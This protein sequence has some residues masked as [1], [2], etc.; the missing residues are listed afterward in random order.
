MGAP[1]GHWT[2]SSVVP[3]KCQQI[4][5]IQ[6]ENWREEWKEF[7]FGRFQ[8]QNDFYSGVWN[9]IEL[10]LSDDDLTAVLICIGAATNVESV[11]LSACH[12]LTGRGLIPLSG[13]T[14]LRRIDISLVSRYHCFGTDVECSL[15]LGEILPV[16]ES[17]LLIGNGLR[18]IQFPKKWR[19]AK[20]EGLS[21]FIA[22]YN[23]ML[24][25]TDRKCCQ[26]FVP[27]SPAI[28]E[29]GDRY[30]VQTATCY[31]CLKDFCHNDDG[32]CES[33]PVLLGVCKGRDTSG[34]LAVRRLSVRDAA[35]AV[36]I[37]AAIRVPM[38]MKS[39]SLELGVNF[40]N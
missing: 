31:K 29:G 25:M 10:S 37:V 27:A 32:N 3:A 13:S 11:Y 24:E 1:S 8:R 14:A 7:D 17:I 36:A 22:R 38:N 33:E 6:Q 16:L 15:E 18:H 35:T 30:G 5:T 4:L 34:C 12:R 20:H 39:E 23:D 9:K 21:H 40:V 26:C 19:D 2:T 28:H